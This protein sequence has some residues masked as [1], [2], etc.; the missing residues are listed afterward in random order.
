[1]VVA[2][3]SRQEHAG[4]GS[5]E[6]GASS[7]AVGDQP[8]KHWVVTAEVHRRPEEAPCAVAVDCCAAAGD[9]PAPAETGRA[10]V[11]RAEAPLAE[12]ANSRDVPCQTDW[13]G[14]A[15]DDP[16][17][18]DALQAAPDDD[19]KLPSAGSHHAQSAPQHHQQGPC[20]VSGWR[21]GVVVGGPY[22]P[23]R[24]LSVIYV[25]LT[26]GPVSVRQSVC[27]CLSCLSTA[28]ACG[29]FADERPA[30]AAAAAPQQMRAVPR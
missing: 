29:G 20:S 8:A 28:A 25:G 5:C 19:Q 12:A 13:T 7:C 26:S 15:P 14:D 24:M 21:R 9:E 22:C 10:D 2:A 30:A 11:P 4:L 27:V 1:V 23:H 6:E 3:S 17:D 18:L 16:V